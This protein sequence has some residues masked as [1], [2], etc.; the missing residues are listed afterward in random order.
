MI[1]EDIGKT[2]DNKLAGSIRILLAV[3]FLMTGAMKLLVP[4]LGEA[5]TEF[6]EQED[7]DF[8]DERK[9]LHEINYYGW[10]AAEVKGGD[11]QA[12]KTISRQ[13]DRVFGL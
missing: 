12:L 3:M 1:L 5:L 13:M 11:L 10:V 6:L 9:A 2:T 4:M 8:A 7:L